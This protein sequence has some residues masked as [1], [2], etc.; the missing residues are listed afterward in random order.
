ML[1][2][3]IRILR[4]ENNLATEKRYFESYFQ[5]FEEES[6]NEPSDG[7]NRW[8]MTCT[9]TDKRL[10]NFNSPKNELKAS[11]HSCVEGS[12]LRQGSNKR[13]FTKQTH[14]QA[15]F[16]LFKWRHVMTSHFSDILWEP[17]TEVCSKV[18]LITVLLHGDNHKRTAAKKA[19][20]GSKIN[21]KEVDRL[22][23]ERKGDWENSQTSLWLSGSCQRKDAEKRLRSIET[24]G[25][26]LDSA[27]HKV[28]NILARQEGDKKK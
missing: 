18:I 8:Q 22:K 21:Q 14:I 25:N 11:L 6:S 19:M 15:I 12:E 20:N 5:R 9:R 13:L 3:H 10:P 28:K 2:N 24:P 17:L 1:W 16:S 27:F 4:R 7:K 26:T 23:T